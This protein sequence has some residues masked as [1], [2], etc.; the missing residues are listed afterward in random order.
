MAKM[1]IHFFQICEGIL[2]IDDKGVCKVGQIP[3]GGVVV[4]RT[5]VIYCNYTRFHVIF[6]KLTV[7][8]AFL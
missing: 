5:T 3:R 4:K 2:F 1:F 8:T 6:T 7:Y